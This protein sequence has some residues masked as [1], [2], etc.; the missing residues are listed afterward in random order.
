MAKRT[1]ENPPD[2]T[3][4]SLGRIVTNLPAVR[5][6]KKIN[7]NSRVSRRLI[8][9]IDAEH[10]ELTFQ[11]SV[12]CQT[13]LPFKNPGDDVRLWKRTQGRAMLVVQAGHVLKPSDDK[14][15][16]VGLPWG[17]KPRLILAHLN[18]LALQ[19]GSPEIEIENSL[20]A[21]VK[22]IRGFDGG[23]ETRM[24]KDQLT[25]L[26]VATIRLAVEWADH[27]TL[28]VTGQIVSQFELWPEKDERQRVLWPSTIKLSQEYFTSLQDHAVPL[29]EEDLAALAHS[30]LALDLYCWLAQRLHRVTPTKPAFITWAALKTQFGPDFDRM[31][32]FKKFFRKALRQVRSRYQRAILDLDSHG[33]TLHHS[34]PPVTK[35][36]VMLSPLQKSGT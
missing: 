28:Q 25:R 15:I 21:F 35:R 33:I 20:S 1:N 14:I 16:D 5:A 29:Y 18:T 36:Q 17:A 23:R 27:R 34:L 13:S 10:D 31:A 7:Q 8:E 19:K 3:Q 2:S 12:F 32:D 22:R 24:F 11:H 30:S 4:M 6:A 26:S 9:P